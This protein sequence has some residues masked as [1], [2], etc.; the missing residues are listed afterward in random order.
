MQNAENKLQLAIH[1]LNMISVNC[2]LK[3]F[4]EETKD[5]AFLAKKSTRRRIII[6][7][8]T[9][10][11]IIYFRHLECSIIYK[12]GKTHE[13]IILRVTKLKLYIVIVKSYMLLYMTKIWILIKQDYR[14]IKMAEMRFLKTV[15]YIFKSFEMRISNKN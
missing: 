15:E 13:N 8:N 10:E 2:N 7:G 14:Q 1:K 4:I 11:Q 9:L 5:K 3:I 12:K 6:E